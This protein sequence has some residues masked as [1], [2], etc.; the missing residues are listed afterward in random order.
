VMLRIAVEVA[1]TVC[2]A[3]CSIFYQTVHR[4]PPLTADRSLVSEVGR[5]RIA[6]CD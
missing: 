6:C 2:G 5:S 3:G 1:G 4:L